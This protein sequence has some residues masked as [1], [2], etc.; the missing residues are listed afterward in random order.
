MIPTQEWQPSDKFS[1]AVALVEAIAREYPNWVRIE[2]SKVGSQLKLHIEQ[3]QSI[4]FPESQAI[5]I[6]G[7][8]P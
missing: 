1:R 7:D 5:T 3:S 2:L 8:K 4:T 6:E